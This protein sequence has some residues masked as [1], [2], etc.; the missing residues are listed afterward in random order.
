MVPHGTVE[1]T[2]VKALGLDPGEG[3]ALVVTGVPD[4]GKGEALVL[5]TTLDLTADTV[6]DKLNAA[7]LTNLWIP[8]TVRRVEKIPILGTG[9]LDLKACQTLALAS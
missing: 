1:A 2:L 6:R 5:L 7:G 9:K 8:R 3:Y 4:P